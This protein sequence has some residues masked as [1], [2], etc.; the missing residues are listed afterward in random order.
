MPSKSILTETAATIHRIHPF[1]IIAES[2]KSSL[3]QFAAGGFR[4]L[5]DATDGSSRF[6]L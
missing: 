6:P 2:A 1:R 3:R 4:A 5:P